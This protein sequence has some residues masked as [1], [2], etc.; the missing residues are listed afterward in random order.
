M[1]PIYDF[2]PKEVVGATVCRE[3]EPLHAP[4]ETNNNNK[5]RVGEKK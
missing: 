4:Y 2:T 5:R 1:G 3:N